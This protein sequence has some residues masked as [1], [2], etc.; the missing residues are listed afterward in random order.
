MKRNYYL[1]MATAQRL[2]VKESAAIIYEIFPE[3]EER[4]HL[5]KKLEEIRPKRQC[6]FN[7]LLDFY[8]VLDSENQ[9]V[10]DVWYNKGLDVLERQTLPHV[11]V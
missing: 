11:I 2:A 1:V 8:M 9:M 6:F 4:D 5:I 10:F 7:A 3:S